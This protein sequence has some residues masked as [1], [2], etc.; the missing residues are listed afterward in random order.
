MAELAA[1]SFP[2]LVVSGGH[3]AGFD[4]MCDEVAERIGAARITIEGA[5]HEVQFTGP[6]IN[7]AMLELWRT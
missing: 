2:K 6:P 4:A 5:G 7:E 1:A 3:S